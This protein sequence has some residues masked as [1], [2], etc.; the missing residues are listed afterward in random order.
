MPR[1]SLLS[2][3][4]R[5]PVIPTGREIL[6]AREAS[7]ALET[8]DTGEKTVRVQ[9]AATAPALDLPPAAVSLLRELLKEMAAGNA[10][11]LVPIEAE[12]TT[13]QAADLLNVS[14]P[15]VVRLIDHAVL[16]A[17]MAGNQRRLPLK[18]VLA[19]KTENRAKRLEALEEISAIDQELGLR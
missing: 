2:C 15:E 19:Y 12:I 7:K 16:P 14:P 18:D 10:V 13:H 8:L 1:R 6:Q 11:M 9:I 3:M 4:R 17:R 5:Q